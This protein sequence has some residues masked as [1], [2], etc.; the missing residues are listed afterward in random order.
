M[1]NSELLIDFFSL[2]EW[3]S[4]P[5]GSEPDSESN[6]FTG[7]THGK[8]STKYINIFGRYPKTPLS[9]Q[10]LHSKILNTAP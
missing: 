7:S 6:D 2:D 10:L 4:S 5:P 1:F 9:K 8:I 3:I